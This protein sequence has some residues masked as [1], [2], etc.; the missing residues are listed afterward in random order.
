MTINDMHSW[1]NILLDHY[2][3]PYFI[4][5]E[6]DEFINS[7]AVEF[8]NDIIFKEYFPSMGENEKGIQ[9]LNSIESV[10]QGSEVL[11]PLIIPDLTVAVAGGIATNTAINS[12]IAASTGDANDTIMHVMSVTYDL[13]GE[14]RLVRYVR[15]N[16][17]A[18]F[19]RNEFKKPTERNPIFSLVRNGLLIEPSNLANVIVSVIKNP[20]KVSKENQIDLDLPEFT[21]QRVIAYALSMSGIASRDDVLVQLQQL[22]GNGTNRNKG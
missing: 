10:I 18:R 20:R 13:S 21:H 11:Q 7:G 1:F 2:N 19:R 15:H 22:S 5:T 8:V 12:A 17:R 16:D 4:D 14:E 3:E 6:I 9:A